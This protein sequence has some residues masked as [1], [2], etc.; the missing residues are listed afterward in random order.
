M[1]A[2]REILAALAPITPAARRDNLELEAAQGIDGALTELDTGDAIEQTKTR[3]TGDKTD[4]EKPEAE[5]AETGAPT[6][7]TG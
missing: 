4:Q 1:E 3:G 6:G 2:A 7:R 5:K